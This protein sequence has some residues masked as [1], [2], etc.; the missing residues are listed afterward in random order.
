MLDTEDTYIYDPTTSTNFHAPTV[1]NDKVTV[2][3]K[4]KYAH[5]FDGAP[6][7]G[8]I[9]VDKIDSYNRR[10]VNLVTKKYLEK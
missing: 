6:F 1:G 10:Q 7:V 2:V 9:E 4:I 8:T 5:V 3:K